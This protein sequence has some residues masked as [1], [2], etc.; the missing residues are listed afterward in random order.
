VSSFASSLTLRIERLINPSWN[1]QMQVRVV[2]LMGLLLI[3]AG[4]LGTLA[5]HP[6][7]SVS[8]LSCASREARPCT[9]AGFD[10]SASVYY[11]Q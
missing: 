1:M 5:Y 6:S 7:K 8:A 2:P 4:T 3:M 9:R 11:T 10:A